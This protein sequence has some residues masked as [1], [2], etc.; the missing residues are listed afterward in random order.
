MTDWL[1][2]IDTPHG[3]T[4]DEEVLLS[5]ADAIDEVRGVTGTGTS[6]NV[7]TGVLSATFMVS[8]DDVQRG[9]EHAVSLFDKALERLGFAPGTVAH[10]E[11]ELTDER[12]PVPV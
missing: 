3:V 10:V 11:A 4:H 6:L 12:E 2:T 1:V 9:V 7:A 8:S 5:F